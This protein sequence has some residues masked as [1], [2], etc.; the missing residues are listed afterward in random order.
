METRS[1]FR[2][3][4]YRTGVPPRRVSSGSR[5]GRTTARRQ[6]TGPM[7]ATADRRRE[8]RRR[9]DRR[10]EETLAKEEKRE[11]LDP[12]RARRPRSRYSQRKDSYKAVPTRCSSAPRKT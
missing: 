8:D 9:E 11:R 7:A 3:G 12:T 6:P 5:R 10:R 2:G 4:S 1:S